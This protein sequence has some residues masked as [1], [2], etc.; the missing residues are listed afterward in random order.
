MLLAKNFLLSDKTVNINL[1]FMIKGGVLPFF[2]VKKI[3]Q[4]SHKSCL[5]MIKLLYLPVMM[6]ISG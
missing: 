6:L 2:I 1:E 4:T 3:C 5:P